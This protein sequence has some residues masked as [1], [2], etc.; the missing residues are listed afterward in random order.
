MGLPPYSNDPDVDVIAASQ[1]SAHTKLDDL[2][3]D[4]DDVKADQLVA[5]QNLSSRFRVYPRTTADQLTVTP[6]VAVNTWSAWTVGIPINVIGMPY[7]V[8]GLVPEFVNNVGNPV[9]NLM[10]QFARAA[11]PANNEILGEVR[12]RIDTAAWIVTVGPMYELHMDHLHLNEGLWI[13]A[14]SSVGATAALAYSLAIIQH[15]HLSAE[16]RETAVDWPWPT[17]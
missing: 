6:G 16:V 8:V 2:E 5:E 3:T 13:R 7:D 1:V 15:Y 14:M 9:R 10:F 17:V 11:A 12:F 4:L